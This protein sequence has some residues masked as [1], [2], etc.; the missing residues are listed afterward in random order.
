MLLGLV[1]V[2]VLSA[3]ATLA[4]V[5]RADNLTTEPYSLTNSGDPVPDPDD[6]RAAVRAAEKFVQLY[7]AFDST[8]VEDYVNDLG[9]VLTT[10]FRGDQ[11]QTIAGL[12]ATF[13]NRRERNVGTVLNSG[14]SRRD[15]DSA[16]VLVLHFL[17]TE[18]SEGNTLRNVRTV[19]EL[20][21]V[22]G[23]WLVDGAALAGSGD[24]EGAA[25]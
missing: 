1:L 8:K 4:L 16:T 12:K 3:V 9:K 24:T 7:D 14:I 18:S 6:A 20:Q 5:S 22:G 21:K 23:K 15:G 10:K 17:Q 11:E 2:L 25:Q 19:V 13:E